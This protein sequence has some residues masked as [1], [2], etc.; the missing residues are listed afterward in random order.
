VAAI[1]DNSTTAGTVYSQTING[2]AQ[3]YIAV[4]NSD[5]TDAATMVVKANRL[6]YRS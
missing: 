1:A 2:W 4:T 6:R 3:A 5:A